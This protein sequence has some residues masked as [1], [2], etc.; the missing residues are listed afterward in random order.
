MLSHHGSAEKLEIAKDGAIY[1][2]NVAAT[3]SGWLMITIDGT[4]VMKV[5]QEVFGDGFESG[6]IS[7]WRF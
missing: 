2:D 6:D 1:L 4:V 3:N 5:A 7:M